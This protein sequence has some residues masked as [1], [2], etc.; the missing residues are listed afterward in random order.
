MTPITIP[1]SPTLNAEESPISPGPN[2]SEG[3]PLAFRPLPLLSHPHVQT[4]L[5]HFL[6]GPT[7]TLPTR[8]QVIHLPDGDGLVLHDNAPPGWRPGDRIALVI[9]GLTGSH[10]SPGVKRVAARLLGHGLRTVRLDQRGT[11]KGLALARGAYHA[12]RSDDVRA[13]LEEIHRWSPASPI[14]LLGIS[15]GG[16]LVLKTAGEVVEHPLPYL[17]RVAAMNPPIDLERCAA[18]IAL[19]RNRMYNRYFSGLL[20]EQARERQGYFPDLPPVRFPRRMSIRLYDD[21]YT[22][23]RGGFKDALDYYR[24]AS[25]YRLLDRIT[26]PTF[27][28]TA[29]DDPFIA[30]EPFEDAKTPNNVVVQITP[31]GGHIGFVGWEGS[32]VVRWAESRILEWIVREGRQ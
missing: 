3:K 14:I 5:G 23:P 2:E 31:K 7:I 11:G 15:L 32:G 20:V 24:R 1:S 16:A 9:H 17:E 13:A 18:L 29:R 21:L 8:E 19:P 10:D 12:G 25:S 30:V 26:V 27:V 4:L 6:P 22:A 28:L